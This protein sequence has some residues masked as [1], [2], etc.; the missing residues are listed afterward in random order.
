MSINL[1]RSLFIPL[2]PVYNKGIYHLT[3]IISVNIF[4]QALL[5]LLPYFWP[6]QVTSKIEFSSPFTLFTNADHAVSLYQ[7]SK[8]KR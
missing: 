6:S 7:A 4:S 8:Q 5:L 3:L 1:P 2:Q